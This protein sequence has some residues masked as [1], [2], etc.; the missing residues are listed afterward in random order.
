M[1]GKQI[2]VKLFALQ[3]TIAMTQPVKTPLILALQAYSRAPTA[4][5]AAK[6]SPIP[7]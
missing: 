5:R 6:R 7:I 1:I 2:V 4:R 3:V